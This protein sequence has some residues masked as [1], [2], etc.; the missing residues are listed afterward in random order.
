LRK[1]KK[2]AVSFTESKGINQRRR[3]GG[4]KTGNANEDRAN[5]QITRAKNVSC[6]FAASTK[7]IK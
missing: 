2:K 3:V 5:V 1:R 4:K 6:T 7:Y